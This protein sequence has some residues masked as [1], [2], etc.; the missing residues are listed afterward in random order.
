MFAPRAILHA[1][2]MSYA[3]VWSVGVSLVLFALFHARG[4]DDPFVTYRYA[5]NLA[6][7]RGFVY[8]AGEHVLSTTSPFYTL[9]LALLRLVG[10]DIP[11]VSNALGC[12]SLGVGGWGLWALFR[13]WGYH[14]GAV[15]ALLL[16]PLSPL[17]ALTI[18]LETTFALALIILG[19]LAY[20]QERFSIAA[21]VFA[22]AVLTRFDALLVV[23]LVG[24]YD[25]VVRR[26]GPPWRAVVLF[27]A[28]V[29]PWFIFATAYF[30]MPLPATLT[31][32]RLQGLLPQSQSFAEGILPFFAAYW[33]VPLYWPLLGCAIVGSVAAIIQLRRGL[34]ILGWVA[35][36]ILAYVFLGVTR[37]AWYYAPLVMG[38]VVLVALGVEAARRVLRA[39]HSGLWGQWATVLLVVVLFGAQVASL[40]AYYRVDNGRLR[41]YRAVGEWFRNT[42]PPDAS[43]AML[44][45]GIIGYYSDRYIIDFAGLIQPETAAHFSPAT[46]V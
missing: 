33:T 41:I 21:V 32:K 27:V 16:Y 3:L 1:D 17:L 14:V 46:S 20:E 42:T 8:N 23:T 39:Y 22:C 6:T 7:G 34:L 24:G 13:R 38:S 15:V 30:G 45:V 26:C 9:L 19:L 5:A 25:V 36:Y 40:V 12:V 2:A 4:F 18:G 44:E 10:F 35:L 31:T 43:I 29:M 11:T 28:L 37:Y